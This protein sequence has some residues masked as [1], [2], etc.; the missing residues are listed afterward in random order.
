MELK[1]IDA[2]GQVS[3]SLSVSDALF[4]RKE[5]SIIL[6]NKK[7]INRFI[8]SV[9]VFFAF[10]IIIEFSKLGANYTVGSV[11]PSDIIAYKDVI[12]TVDIL[13]KGIN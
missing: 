1:V 13:D 11:A 7:F 5:S 4:G 6:S 12:Y 10:G 3:G 8:W 2:K 9:L